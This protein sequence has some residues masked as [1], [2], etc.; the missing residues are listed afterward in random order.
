M[1]GPA[2]RQNVIFRNKREDLSPSRALNDVRRESSYG[3]RILERQAGKPLPK[4]MRVGC[5]RNPSV[6]G[7]GRR[8]G[9]EQRICATPRPNS[10]YRDLVERQSR[11]LAWSASRADDKSVREDAIGYNTL[12][13][14]AGGL[15]CAK[16]LCYGLPRG[17][18]PVHSI[19]GHRHP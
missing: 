18:Q 14:G 6:G 17:K 3:H 19:S 4:P 7:P 16:S 5:C 13:R 1:G 2:N 9:L 12:D 15:H 10:R 11:W 8:L